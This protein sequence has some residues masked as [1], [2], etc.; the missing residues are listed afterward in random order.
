MYSGTTFRI[1]SGRVAGVHQKIDRVA[2][3]HLT[4]HLSGEVA[5]PSIR[6]ILHFEGLNG[7]DG[8]KRKSP[9]RDEPWHYIDPS[10]PD[11]RQLI[12]MIHN[13]LYNLSIALR[14]DNTERAA[15][16]AAWVAHAVTDGLTPAHHYPLADKIEELFGKSHHERQTIREKN[17]IKGTSP[18]D[19]ISKNWQYWGSRGIFTAHFLFEWGVATTIAPL[20]LDYDPLDE[21]DIDRLAS[22]G[23]EALF[24]EAF[25][26]IVAMNMY[27]EY[28]RYG[29]TRHLA[30]ETRLTLIPLIIKLVALAWYDAA[31]YEPEELR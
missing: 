21:D 20:K 14:A 2:R 12:D 31:T 29:W 13:H 30:D 9:S 6:D 18:R 17:I 27:E 7:P 22:D 16:E 23:F 10:K 26:T 3:R 4:R 5:F 28:V 8:I 19:T 15:F 1:K 25:H 11:D 24:Y